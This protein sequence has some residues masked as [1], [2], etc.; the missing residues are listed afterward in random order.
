MTARQTMSELNTS[1]KDS[2]A[3]ATS[4]CEWPAM[5]AVS[6]TADRTAFVTIPRK[7]ARRLR[8]RRVRGTAKCRISNFECRI[9]NSIEQAKTRK[10]APN[11]KLQHPEKHQLSTS[12]TDAP[13]QN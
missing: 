13:M 10:K 11:S 6:L 3:S 5:P 7:V 1:A 9:Q 2:T 8:W 4:A 12:Q